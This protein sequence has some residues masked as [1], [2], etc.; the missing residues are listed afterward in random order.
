MNN[1]NELKVVAIHGKV[2]ADSRDVAEMVEK[3]H[4]HLLADIRKYLEIL[5]SRDYGSEKFFV[6][7]TYFNNRNQIQP[8]Y[9]LTRAG[10]DMVANKMSGE[11]GVLFTAAYVTRFEEM[12]QTLN[13]P[14]ILSPAEQ[15]KASM[16][17]SLETSEEL[18]QV[19]EDV[20]EIRS[21]VENRITLDHGEQRRLQKAVGAR[22]YTVEN[23]IEVRKR[24]FSELYREIKDRFAVTSYKDV[25]H[26][27]LQSAIHYV[28][29]WIPK[30]K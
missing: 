25:K 20:S 9:L 13:A 19:K 15:L 5:H 28:D 22:I 26:Q 2:V 17:L 21:M 23:D 7:S 3:R 16:R 18:E 24:L 6:E 12:E 30:Q 10:C 1:I 4:D 29:A 11:K 8:C 27:D 14:K